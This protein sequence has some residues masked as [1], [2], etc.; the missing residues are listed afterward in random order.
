MCAPV[1]SASYSRARETASWINMAAIGAKIQASQNSDSTGKSRGN[2]RD[3]DI[4]IANVAQF[5]G[6]HAFELFV[7]EDIQN[8][9]S[10]GNGRVLRIASRSERVRRIC[11]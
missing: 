2:R 9:L 6:Q 7:I 4:A 8:S 1:A 10:H 11:W 5:V 3:Q